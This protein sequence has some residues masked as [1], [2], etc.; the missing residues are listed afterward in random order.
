MS[1]TQDKF[2][3]VIREDARYLPEAYGFLHEALALAVERVHDAAVEKDRHVSGQ[4]LSAALRDL[5]RMRYGL[6]AKTVL[7]SWGVR[8]SIDFGN[9]VY[10][11]IENELMGKADG[12]SIEDFRDQFDTETDLDTLADIRFCD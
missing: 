4:Q 7:Q 1:D 9:M 11:L 10:L 5:A 8:K 6:M 2:E 12:D 3:T